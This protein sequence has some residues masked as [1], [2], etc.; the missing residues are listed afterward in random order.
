MCKYCPDKFCLLRK[1][2]DLRSPHSSAS[3]SCAPPPSKRDSVYFE[4]VIIVCWD[5][6]VIYL[7]PKTHHASKINQPMMLPIPPLRARSSLEFRFL[8]MIECQHFLL[9]CAVNPCNWEQMYL[10][11]F[12]HERTLRRYILSTKSAEMCSCS[13]VHGPGFQTFVF[14]G[15][16]RDDPD[17]G[18]TLQ[19]F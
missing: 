12:W 10:N 3:S 15:V 11:G 4:L 18:P 13:R 19:K 1:F 6:C 16:N 9:F 8:F 7:P 2:E 17:S 14:R 5:H